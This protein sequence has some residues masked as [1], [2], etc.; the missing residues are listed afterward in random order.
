MPADFRRL[1]LLDEGAAF[2]RQRLDERKRLSSEDELC[3]LITNWTTE[4][5][6]RIFSVP[7]SEADL[8]FWVQVSTCHELTLLIEERKSLLC[9]RAD[10]DCDTVND[11]VYWRKNEGSTWPRQSLPGRY[12]WLSDATSVRSLLKSYRDTGNAYSFLDQMGFNVQKNS[13]GSPYKGFYF[14]FYTR[15]LLEHLEDAPVDDEGAALEPV[16]FFVPTWKPALQAC[17]DFFL[18]P[19]RV[20]KDLR[21]WI[22]G[23]SPAAKEQWLKAIDYYEHGVVGVGGND[24]EGGGNS[25]GEPEMI[26][27]VLKYAASNKKEWRAENGNGPNKVPD[28]TFEPFHAVRYLLDANFGAN[29]LFSGDGYTYDR[30]PKRGQRE[31]WASSFRSYEQ[32]RVLVTES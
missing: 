2:F 13:D 18:R 11:D 24:S 32:K 15:K 19:D 4:D 27:R 8:E 10:F 26:Q 29:E 16:Q 25:T 6:K 20:P 23:P 9:G 7:W 5:K 14:L 1:Q 22:L 17:R 21:E 3:E 12:G 30:E 31:Y 28:P